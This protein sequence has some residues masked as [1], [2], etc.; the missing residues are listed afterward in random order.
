MKY[1]EALKTIAIRPL[2]IYKF[3]GAEYVP[4][5]EM[6]EMRRIAREALNGVEDEPVTP[7]D[8]GTA[9]NEVPDAKDNP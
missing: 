7:E 4:A 1:E 9:T 2:T 5:R 8:M 6:R 3:E